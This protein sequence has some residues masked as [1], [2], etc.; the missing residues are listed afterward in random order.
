MED[1]FIKTLEGQIITM[2]G[3]FFYAK[4]LFLKSEK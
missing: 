2:H 4:K 1:I 3:Y